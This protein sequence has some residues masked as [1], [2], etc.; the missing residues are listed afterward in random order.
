MSNENINEEEVIDEKEA[1]KREIFGKIYKVMIALVIIFLIYD[2]LFPIECTSESKVI[3]IISVAGDHAVFKFDNGK[4]Q[5]LVGANLKRGDSYC[6]S[7]ER[8]NK[9]FK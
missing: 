6:T 8:K 1:K 4:T 7:S 5:E 9:Y 3:D 2:K